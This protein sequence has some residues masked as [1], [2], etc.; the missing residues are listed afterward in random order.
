MAVYIHCKPLPNID[1]GIFSDLALTVVGARAILSCKYGYIIHGT[2]NFVCDNE[3][4]W[5]GTASCRKNLLTLLLVF[6]QD[7]LYII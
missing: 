1:N 2:T 5:N 6:H 4:N 3:G 7:R